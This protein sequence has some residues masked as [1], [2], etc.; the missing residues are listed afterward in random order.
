MYS[1]KND[2]S[3]VIKGAEKGAAVIVYDREDYQKQ[4]SKQLEDK[5]AYLEVP[6]DSSALVSTISRSLEKIGKRG[7]LL[8]N[9]LNYF[10][11]GF[12]YYLKFING[13]MI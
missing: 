3:I 13:Y 7:D 4:A 6:N 10:L 9:T 2:K 11:G 1:L 5:E 8:Q 12:T